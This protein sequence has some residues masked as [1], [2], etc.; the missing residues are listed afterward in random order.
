MTEPMATMMTLGRRDAMSETP[1]KLYDSIS[2][3]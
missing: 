2:S 3:Q 1:K